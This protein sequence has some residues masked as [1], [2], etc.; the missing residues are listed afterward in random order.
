MGHYTK[1]I[2]YLYQKTR[3]EWR[4]KYGVFSI[5][6]RHI[7]SSCYEKLI[8]GGKRMNYLKKH[9][10]GILFAV[11]VSLITLGLFWVYKALKK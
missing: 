8:K 4:L 3:T 5:F 11:G 9:S 6:N 2:N 10:D 7:Y 1:R